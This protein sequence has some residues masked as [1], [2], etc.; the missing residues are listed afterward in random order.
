MSKTIREI[1]D[2]ISLSVTRFLENHQGVKNVQ[3]F[4]RTGVG[5]GDISRWERINA[6]FQLPDDYKSFL[7]I[8]DGL[9][10]KWSMLYQDD[11][12]PLGCMQLNQLDDVVPI[13]T[14]DLSDSE[15][16][17]PVADGARKR[18][19]SCKA[20]DIDNTCLDGR[21]CFLFNQGH[22]TPQI[23][24]QDLSCSWHFIANTFTD[25]FRLMVMHLGLPHWQYAFTDVGLDAVSQQ[26][27]RFLSPERL[28]IDIEHIKQRTG[29]SAPGD[30]HVSR[31]NLSKVVRSTKPPGSAKRASSV[32]LVKKRK[33]S[34]PAALPSPTTAGSTVGAALSS[35]PR[36]P[37]A[38]RQRPPSSAGIPLAPQRKSVI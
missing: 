17:A 25:Y 24:F 27:F 3:F 16:D 9:L 5:L 18:V 29:K 11:L 14:D 36:P 28:A 31:L 8:G 23:W 20:F 1:F 32:T 2:D 7:I 37:S 15:D 35:A 4:E 26:W 19:S 13:P 12:L 34:L 38:T 10:L 21:V 33:D 6:P 22:S 30:P